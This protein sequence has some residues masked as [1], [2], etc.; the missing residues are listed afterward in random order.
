MR[1]S[2]TLVFKERA[3]QRYDEIKSKTKVA[4]EL[5]I[6]K[7]TFIEW[8]AQRAKIVDAIRASKG[9]CEK[10]HAGPA[11]QYP[12]SEDRLYEWFQNE[13]SAGRAVSNKYLCARFKQLAGRHAKASPRWL[14]GNC[15]KFINIGWKKRFSVSL[16]VGTNDSQHLPEEYD[17]VLQAFRTSVISKMEELSLDE[18][19][20]WNMDQTMVRFDNPDRRTN[21][22]IGESRIRITNTGATRKGF[23]VALC[24]SASGEKLPAF[25]IFKERSGT[26]PTRVRCALEIPDNVV[27]E[28]SLN[29]WMTA[30]L[31]RV[32]ID[33]I[34]YRHVVG[35]S[36]ILLD[37]YKP[38]H[39]ASTVERLAAASAH[40]I[41]IP[42]GI[43]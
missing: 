2:Y 11:I 21:N 23:T 37:Q 20:V 14:Q 29:G 35:E 12:V 19:S 10:L 43:T 41:G 9:T 26:I 36:I 22:T 38:H 31:L 39:T 15:L 5:G 6:S 8:V 33:L 3:I 28:A 17:A 30:P 34:F 4:K 40:I 18:S 7:K 13:R 25:I 1:R 24:V 27:V 16:R 32:W 42:G